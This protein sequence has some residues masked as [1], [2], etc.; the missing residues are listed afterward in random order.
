MTDAKMT[1][2]HLLKRSYDWALTFWRDH[3]ASGREL[4]RKRAD[5]EAMLDAL[6]RGSAESFGG[7]VLVDASFDNPNYWFRFS[8]LRAAL[9]LTKAEEIGMLGEFRVRYC[10]ATLQRLGIER[11]A[12]LPEIPVPASVHAEADR[13]I[14][15]TKR[16]DDI[17]AWTLPENIDSAIIYDGILKRQRLAAVDIRCPNFAR[18]VHDALAAI[19]RSRRLLDTYKFD[20]LV[21]SHPLNFV[22]GAL[23]WQ[24]LARG[25][26]VVLPFGLFG[27]LRFSR[28][29]K[30]RDLMRFYDRPTRAEIDGLAPARAQAMAA[31]GRDYMR[32]RLSGAA[33][34]LASQY[35]FQRSRDAIDRDEMCRRF[36]W[37]PAK[38]IVGFYAS[39]WYDWPH[40]LGMTQFRDF[41]DWT[42]ASYRA[43]I[44][45]T[46]VNWLFKAH[47]VE[48]WFGGI[49]LA[50]F[51]AGFAGAAHVALADKRWNNGQ[52]MRCLDA[53]ITYHG[54]AGV[55]FAAQAKP[56]LVP[57]RGKYDD[58]GFVMVAEN[59]A[60]YLDLLARD[61][62]RDMDLEEVRRRA[63]IFA[64]WWFCM[65]EWQRGFVLEEDATQGALYDSIPALL[66][67]RGD[68]IER[69]LAELRA[70]WHS[71]HHYYHTTKMKRAE[72]YVL[73]NMSAPSEPRVMEQQ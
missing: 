69:E 23:A 1:P 56:V 10:G 55:E 42:E 25:I 41:L 14:A 11:V 40:Q 17:L 32:G 34:D 7:R 16:P 29:Y 21:V 66:R 13:L 57:D 39:N 60:H 65:P 27:G 54:T 5:A 22:P 64:G 47:P 72:S 31:V 12:V 6:A 33:G 43:A 8:L 71:G 36:G 59:R 44:A 45:N 2:E 20:L 35:A 28:F 58:C 38:P 37:D 3:S 19:E 18:L 67:E 26:E 9:G 62:W 24:A 50:D 51:F 63:E 46:N 15:A 30:P 61:W 73:S 68:V 70:W 53:L 49:A 48:D 52:V 4:L